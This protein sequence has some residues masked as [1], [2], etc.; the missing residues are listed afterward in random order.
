MVA[1]PEV[2]CTATGRPG[3]GG[4]ETVPKTGTFVF[5][6]GA[7][8]AM[9][10]NIPDTRNSS[11]SITADV[12]IPPTGAE[13]VLF[14]IGGRFSGL[15]LYIQDSHLVFDYNFLGIKHHTIVSQDEIAAGPAV[16]GFAFNKTGPYHGMG[17]LYIN[18]TQQ[19]QMPIGPTVPNRYSFEEG[20][21]IGKDPQTP[22]NESY[23]SP[24]S[25]T[26]T[27][28]KVVFEAEG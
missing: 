11:Y 7:E 8:K 21:E 13:G 27:L 16:M 6:A 15:S 17:T 10:P 28:K 5:Y 24:F 14:S 1:G 19:G 2:Q 12:E 4:Y 22:V 26:G 23:S 3:F 20:L 9:E 18:G 25:F